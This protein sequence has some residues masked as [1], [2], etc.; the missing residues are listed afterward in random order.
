MTNIDDELATDKQVRFALDLFKKEAGI[1]AHEVVD[2]SMSRKWRVPQGDSLREALQSMTKSRMS[3]LID[4]LK[5][6]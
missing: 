5:G 3:M 4:W 1:G 6:E 2:A